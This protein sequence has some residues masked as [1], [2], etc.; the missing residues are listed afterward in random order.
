MSVS[1]WKTWE[2]QRQV[3]PAGSRLSTDSSDQASMPPCSMARAA[4]SKT[5]GATRGSPQAS[6]RSTV[7]GVPQA[8]WRLMHQSG[9]P[10]IMAEM[11]FCPWAGI[12]WVCSTPSIPS[13]RRLR[14]LPVS[15][16]S[17]VMNH[18][19]VARKRMGVRVRQQCG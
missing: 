5:E 12:H 9:R 10:A 1:F 4:A 8:R 6:Q 3:E 13:S 15:S 11:R 14:P 16:E 7:M 18:C 19:S 17:M 2:P